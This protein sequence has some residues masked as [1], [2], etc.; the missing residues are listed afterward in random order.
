MGNAPNPVTFIPGAHPTNTTVGSVLGSALQK[1]GQLGSYVPGGNQLTQE[2]SK[3]PVVGSGITEGLN[4]APQF[5]L[6]GGGP[7]TTALGSAGAVIGG[8]AEAGAAKQF[9]LP[10]WAQQAARI[11][12]SIGGGIAGAQVGSAA[13]SALARPQGIRPDMSNVGEVPPQSATDAA[14]QGAEPFPN[15]AGPAGALVPE[16]V[17][18]PNT[19]EPFFLSQ[20]ELAQRAA[21]ELNAEK[22]AA[23]DVFGPQQAQEYER[24]QRIANSS[25]RPFAEQDAA[26][27]QIQ[28]ME[29]GLTEQQQNHL[30]GIGEEGYNAEQY[31]NF[32][33]AAESRMGD[34]RQSLVNTVANNLGRIKPEELQAFTNGTGTLGEQQQIAAM[35]VREAVNAFVA[36]GGTPDQIFQL[37]ARN[38]SQKVGPEDAQYLMQD[39][40][41]LMAHGGGST[42]A[43]AI[44]GP[45]GVTPT[46]TSGQAGAPQAAERGAQSFPNPNP[47]AGSEIAQHGGMTPELQ[48]RWAA[49]QADIK[50][51]GWNAA[52]KAEYRAITGRNPTAALQR[53]PEAIGPVAAETPKV[54]NAEDV[55]PALKARGVSGDALSNNVDLAS[56][57]IDNGATVNPDGTVRLYHRTTPEAAQQIIA[58]GKM[59]GA[60]DGVFFSTAPSGQAEGFGSAVV[61]VDVPLERLQLDDVFGNEAHVRIPTSRPG[62]TV[63]VN[64]APSAGQRTAADVTRGAGNAIVKGEGGL[65][66]EL[67]ETL[68]LQK[69][70]AALNDAEVASAEQKANVSALRSRQAGA[71]AGAAKSGEGEAGFRQALGAMRGQAQQATFTP[72]RDSLDP[73]EIDTLYNRVLTSDTR[74]F[75]QATAGNALGKLLDGQPPTRSELDA[76]GR[77]FGPEQKAAVENT[78]KK[79]GVKF[80][81]DLWQ[82]IKEDPIN[83]VNNS[84]RSANTTLDFAF[85]SRLGPTAGLYD[86]PTYLKAVGQSWKS[87]WEPQIV[88]RVWENLDAAAA[89]SGYL[90]NIETMKEAGLRAYTSDSAPGLLGKVPLVGRAAKV[91]QN[92]TALVR[93]QMMQQTVENMVK[94][95][96]L[97]EA[98]AA[99]PAVLADIAKGINNITGASNLSWLRSGG[100]SASSNFL[101]EFPNWTASQFELIVRA[102]ANGSLSGQMARQALARLAITG[103]AFAGGVNLLQGKNPLSLVKNGVPQMAIPGTNMTVDPYGPIGEL[104]QHGVGVARAG[105]EGA[106]PNGPTGGINIPGGAGSTASELGWWGRGLLSPVLKIASDLMIGKNIVGQPTRDT[107]AHT[108]EYFGR[109]VSPFSAS[110]IGQ[111]PPLAIGLSSLGVRGVREPTAYANLK[112]IAQNQFASQIGPGGVEPFMMDAARKANPTLADEALGKSNDTTKA[113]DAAKQKAATKQAA[114]DAQ[115]LKD[116]N[117]TAWKDGKSALQNELSGEFQQIYGNTAGMKTD[118]NAP[119][120]VYSDVIN[121]NTD[122]RGVTDWTAVDAWRAQHDNDPYGNTGQ[123]WGQVIDRNIG[124]NDTPLEAQRRQVNQQLSQAEFFDIR[125]KVWQ[126][127]A[128]QSG[129]G[130]Y[131]SADSFITD[132]TTQIRARLSAGGATPAQIAIL[133]PE[134]I[135]QIPQIK[136]WLSVSNDVEQ[137]WIQANPRLAAQAVQYG[138]LNPDTMRG[139]EKAAVGQVTQ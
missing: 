134:I 39:W 51:N 99:D 19:Y 13:Q 50:A 126:A 58:T 57:L 64:V 59:R 121:Q 101:L 69:L 96:T 127:I 38:L 87:M 110:D 80:Q 6:G 79:M 41:S 104:I 20:D 71:F 1:S 56:E 115:V 30:F 105:Y 7:L 31:K 25:M 46:L 138:Y 82:Q 89:D 92:F 73:S 63:D 90:P 14:I 37:A 52:N 34:S 74:P 11:Y 107:Q 35:R 60:E 49:M 75:E 66:A 84:I 24:L 28:R 113:W 103:T 132:L 32:A 85:M 17:P 62:A 5:A 109:T 116:G 130:D 42:S 3:I 26:S 133:T 106:T 2:T 40:L 98:Q 88:D 112:A 77:V 27:A 114:L 12:G 48:A 15:P 70:Q 43:A 93:P 29:A 91:Y 55:A 81:P 68:P 10:D 54:T 65:S 45:S 137:A 8:R 47:Y 86:P 4:M 119:W 111:K 36:Q 125:P 118:P 129:L 108:L 18:K 61:P 22:Q 97:T 94:A 72:L 78:L 139:V 122:N 67:P 135:D 120:Q 33:K 136:A 21:S 117:W 123:T 16:N 128:S 76:F 44:T 100:G 131:K 83:A 102:A 9:G 95:G 53:N 23:I 124:L